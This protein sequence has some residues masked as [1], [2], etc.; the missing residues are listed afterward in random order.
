ME[1]YVDDYIALAVPTSQD[2]LDHVANGV[3][4]GIYDAFPKDDN[5]DNNPISLKKLKKL[6]ESWALQK[7]M[8]GFMFDG[9]GKTL[10][11]DAAKGDVLLTI[12]KG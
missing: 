6:K 10:W 1:V 9:D 7:D 2:Q 4:L 12:L 8:L 5:D 11:L 3:L